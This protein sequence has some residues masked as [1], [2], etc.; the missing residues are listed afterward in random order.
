[1]DLV[2]RAR[3]E[4]IAMGA[5]PRGEVAVRMEYAAE[6][7]P[8][9]YTIINGGRGGTPEDTVEV[10]GARLMK[11]PVAT[12]LRP[13]P[14]AY[15]LP[16]DAEAAVAMLLRH[17]ITV[18]RLEAPARLDVD[19]YTIA[20]VTYEQAYNHA[21]AVRVQVGDVR[22]LTA[23]LPVG[24]YVVPTAQALGRL[25][26]HM[27]EPETD[28]NVIYWNTMDAWLPRPGGAPNGDGGPPLV[29]I[30]KLMSPAALESS[31]VRSAR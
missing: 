29:P 30:Y 28:D 19:A 27:L 21:A 20:D 10:R 18:E 22:R 7:Y 26:A 25:V 11:R 6:N 15:I 8:V 13:R 4:T 12:R 2:E 31:L 9:D 14:W 16:R 23:D 24:T 1:M 17:G 5:E 3:T